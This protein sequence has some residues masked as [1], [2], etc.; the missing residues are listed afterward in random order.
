MTSEQ[1]PYFPSGVWE[2]HYNYM[3]GP[4]AHRHPMSFHLDFK[5]G[6]VTGTGSDDVGVFSWDGEYDTENMSCRMVK[7]YPTHP[8]LYDGRAD[9]SGIYGQ[10]KIHDGLS[11]GFH[12]WPRK[13]GEAVEEEE[14]AVAEK[15]L[16]TVA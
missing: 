12:I 5:D 14:V 3:A 1:H 2:G 4:S 10:W 8:V 11:G 6:R 16:A 13:G 7:A 15:V 9:E